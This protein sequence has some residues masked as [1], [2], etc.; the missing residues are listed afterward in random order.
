MHLLYYKEG[1][2]GQLGT[3]LGNGG[4]LGTVLDFVTLF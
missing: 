4:Q 2:G 3:V 1:N